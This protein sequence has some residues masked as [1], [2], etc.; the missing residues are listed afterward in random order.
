MSIISN[1][2]FKS[3]LNPTSKRYFVHKVV[4]GRTMVSTTDPKVISQLFK[5][6]EQSNFPQLLEL[7]LS[8]HCDPRSIHNEK[9]ESLLDIA[10]RTSDLQMIRLLVKVY[11]CNSSTRDTFDLCPVD[12][13]HLTGHV[14]IVL[15]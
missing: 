2:G 14:D 15:Y 8:N 9:K 4:L 10:S 1:V 13:S 6:V 7:I 12:Y 3:D 5:A 11:M